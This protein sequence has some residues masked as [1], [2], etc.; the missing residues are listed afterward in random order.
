MCEV[1]LSNKLIGLH[2]KRPRINVSGTRIGCCKILSTPK[3]LWNGGLKPGL[4]AAVQAGHLL[5]WS[6]WEQSGTTGPPK[7]G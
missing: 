6:A 4:L 7:Q 5:I 3:W 1:H 2:E